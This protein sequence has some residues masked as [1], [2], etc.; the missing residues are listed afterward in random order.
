MNEELNDLYV[1]FD[2]TA[3]LQESIGNAAL[4]LAGLAA[5]DGT[6]GFEMS[7]HHV[8]LGALDDSWEFEKVGE[9]DSSFLVAR[10]NF[11]EVRISAFL[12]H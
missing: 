8:P 3:S 5:N 10:K 6:R 4:V 12:K 1:K 9:G 2:E 11:G 7:I